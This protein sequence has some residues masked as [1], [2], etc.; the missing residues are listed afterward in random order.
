[1]MQEKFQ[2]DQQRLD[3]IPIIDSVIEKIGLPHLLKEG[4]GNERYAEA[5]LVLLKNIL[6]ERNALYAIQEWSAQYDPALVYGGKLSDDVFARSLDRLFD[7]DRASLMTRI[8]LSAVKKYGIDLSQIHQDTTSVKMTGVYAHQNPK[9]LKI[10][11]GH[12][13]DHRPDLKQLV[14]ELSV[15]RDGAIPIL[16]KAHDGNRTDDTVH[17]DNWQTLRGILGRSNF[18]YV[19]DSKLCV[20][21]VLLDID[22]N[23]GRFVTILPRTRSEV[24]QFN[25]KAHSALVRWEKV[26]ARKAGKCGKIDLFEVASGLH[27]MR[28]G[29][30][31]FWFRSSEK[32][33][34]DYKERE[35]K[36]ALAVDHIRALADPKRKKRPKTEKAMRKRTDAI[37][38]R[39]GVAD[40]ITVEIALERVEKFKQAR[41]GRSSDDSMFRRVIHW[42]PS[43]ECSRNES[44]ISQA[45][46]MDGI[47][48]LATNTDLNALAVLKAYKYQPK[49][50]RRHALMKSGLQ[51]APVFLKKNDRIEA[52]M[53]VY[54]L[55]QLTC[56]LVERQL[57]T[58]MREQGLKQIK[59]LPE[60]RPSA[61]P[62]AEQIIRVFSARARH[63]LLSKRGEHMQTF[64]DPLTPIQSQ[65]LDLLSISHT[66]YA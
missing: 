25:Q 41:R 56:A 53:F 36:I 52:L 17:W 42:I 58:A 3:A 29:F 62:T 55:A 24:V 48:P 32:A 37:L 38:N 64:S 26:A 66:V 40:W 65:V 31:L 30:R 21:K 19:A 33:R 46:A 14:Y 23:Q 4:I 60:D 1:M 2:L 22:R 45:S 44:A 10:A 51:V 61:A 39:F 13:K 27:Q 16:F 8:V 63:L 15:T 49:L 11:R 18:L 54:F 59:I 20:S 5:I 7:A 6:I 28:E 35:E 12:S 57:R 9:A 50:E 47:F 43:I 34:R